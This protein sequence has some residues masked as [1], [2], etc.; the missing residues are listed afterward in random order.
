MATTAAR[1]WKARPTVPAF[2]VS[3]ARVRATGWGLVIREPW[4]EVIAPIE[5]YVRSV[6]LALVFGFFL[7]AALVTLSVGR[8]TA[9]IAALVK[10]T[11]RVARG[12]FSIRVPGDRHQGDRRAGQARSTS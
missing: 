11:G 10:S 9:P 3:F 8:V 2:V 1:S 5:P 7:A 4:G 12:D 6:L